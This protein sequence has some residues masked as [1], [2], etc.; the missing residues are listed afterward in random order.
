MTMNIRISALRRII[1]EAARKGKR[2]TP[3]TV[4]DAG[5]KFPEAMEAMVANAVEAGVPEDEAIESLD[6][7]TYWVDHR[8]YLHSELTFEQLGDD[9][10]DPSSKEWVS[11]DLDPPYDLRN[12]ELPEKLE[13][14]K[15]KHLP[16]GPLGGLE[17]GKTYVFTNY[18]DDQ[19]NH[20]RTAGSGF[21][22]DNFKAGDKITIT[23]IV[24]SDGSVKIFYA[25]G[26]PSK[27]VY[28]DAATALLKLDPVSDLDACEGAAYLWACDSAPKTSS[29]IFAHGSRAASTTCT[30]M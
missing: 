16:S 26:G 8:G 1:R 27:Y 13:K 15:K 28:V 22:P 23:D 6:D 17:I 3:I 10:W 5:L 11:S 20:G 18:G 2:N 21:M 4:Q 30:S 7:S 25:A 19:W 12:Y 14:P 24:P 9:M 29:T